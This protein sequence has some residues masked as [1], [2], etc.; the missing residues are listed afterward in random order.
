MVIRECKRTVTL[1]NVPRGNLP[2]MADE[3]WRQCKGTWDR[4]RWARRRRY[5]DKTA[6]EVAQLLGIKPGTYNAYEGEPGVRSKTLKLDHQHAA[7]IAKKFRVRWEWLLMGEGEPWQAEAD[8][9]KVRAKRAIDEAT[10]EQAEAAADLLERLF[11]KT[12][13]HG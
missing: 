6:K 11:G 13:T 8:S 10:D 5:G 3:S 4:L 1:G 2:H 12:G 9:P 7:H